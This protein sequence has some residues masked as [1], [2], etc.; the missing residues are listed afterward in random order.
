MRLRGTRGLSLCVKVS[1]LLTPI[2]CLSISPSCEIRGSLLEDPI[3]GFIFRSEPAGSGAQHQT[4]SLRPTAKLQVSSSLAYPKPQALRFS[5]TPALINASRHSPPALSSH[6]HLCH[7]GRLTRIRGQSHLFFGEF[8]GI[9]FIYVTRRSIAMLRNAALPDCQTA[10]ISLGN[11]PPGLNPGRPCAPGSSALL[12][13]PTPTASTLT[14]PLVGLAWPAARSRH[15]FAP[16]PVRTRA[17]STPFAC[18]AGRSGVDG[19][20]RTAFGDDTRTHTQ[21][22]TFHYRRQAKSLAEFCSPP[23]RPHCP[24]C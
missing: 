9:P 4:P 14:E 3:Y 6:A 23:I 1:C 20:T 24:Q 8:M 12:L 15:T 2:S 21:S 16:R 10:T 17:A 5:S 18:A 19:F 11:R 13:R 7:R 22:L